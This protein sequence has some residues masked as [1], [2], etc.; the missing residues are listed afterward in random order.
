MEISCEI[1]TKRRYK[2]CKKLS[3]NFLPKQREIF[4]YLNIHYLLGEQIGGTKI[5]RM[6][7]KKYK[8]LI[9]YDKRVSTNN[10]IG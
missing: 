2:I 9:S 1:K 8:F 10:D 7:Y 3:R 6:R 4:N 5:F